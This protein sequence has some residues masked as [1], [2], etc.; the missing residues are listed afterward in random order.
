M[1]NGPPSDIAL[2]S[3]RSLELPAVLEEA[4]A[5]AFSL[6]GRLAVLGAMPETDLERIRAS[7]DL[8]QELV[9]LAATGRSM[10]FADL[11]PM[12]GVFA[13]VGHPAGILDAEEILAV[14][15]I[16]ALAEA[17]GNRVRKLDERFKLLRHHAG[18][19]V[20]L[21]I[22]R[23]RIDRV[24][25]PHGGIRP[26]ASRRLAAIHDRTRSVRHRIQTRLDGLVGDR[27]LARIV[28]EDYIA[29]RNDRYVILLRPEFKGMLDGIVH[30]H[31]RSGASVYV[32]PLEV[33]DLNN[34]I[35]SLA[36]EERE[37]QRRIL[38]ELTED[39]RRDLDAV[40]KNYEILSF[41]DAFQARALY[42]G[43]TSSVV[44][45][46]VPDGFRIL[47]ARHPL[48]PSTGESG[49]VPMDVIQDTSTYATV[50]SGANMGG[51]TVA[52]K[53]AGLFPLMTRCGIM[54]PAREGTQIQPFARVMA[55]IGDEQDIRNRVSSF[56]GHMLR[57]KAVI[58]AVA[59]G[60]LVLLDELGGATDPEE[61]AGLAMAVIDRLIEGKARVV[62]TT[63][64]TNL[65]AYALTRSDVRNVSVEF[66]PKTLVPTFR[67]LYDL[68]GE[69]HA[70]ETA[71]RI[72]MDPTVIA[73]ARR[74]ADKAAGGGTS[75]IQSLQSKLSEVDG[76][77]EELTA[78]RQSLQEEIERLRS[79]RGR[80][81]EEFREAAGE[82]M[83]NAEKQISDLQRSVKDGTM[84]SRA[85]P[86][87][88]LAHIKEEIVERLGTPLERHVQAPGVGSRVKVRSLGSGGTVKTVLDGGRVEVSAGNI[89]IRADVE[90]LEV[91]DSTPHKK[92]LS[93]KTRF[94]I[95]IPVASPKWEVNVIGLRVHEALP[96]I[97]KALD[98][99]VLGGLSSMSVVHGK[100]TGRLKKG[101]RDCLAGHPL[102]TR[103]RPGTIEQGGEG[104]T[105]VELLSE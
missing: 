3:L 69:S 22:L 48:L 21:E 98:E 9:E 39:I 88:T 15:D 97:E 18:G 35:A 64:L 104:V 5:H 83:R 96:I 105:V 1:N 57:I 67:L 81:V 77:R 43:A 100:G 68:P 46:I 74:Y 92:E 55:D 47:G 65:K 19:L 7:L 29:M 11:V 80:V 8:V 52:L 6:P 102:V 49:V 36:D 85:K 42:A 16:L 59:P 4:A 17:T 70:I 84:K 30:D 78:G 99:A 53:I 82:M 72:G 26:T 73:A 76:L 75:L 24:F 28:Q 44:P 45:E 32:E 37:E 50:I 87:E 10:G 62:V 23:A 33:V 20:P 60:D 14:G 89:T 61:G 95:D 86:R 34:Q 13:S 12:E 27:D 2:E 103:F 66:H 31:S 101:V 63:H 40:Q 91:L 51:K 58:D 93:T 54:L 71:E 56:S 79:D 41:L 25:D 38:H 90:D 94:G